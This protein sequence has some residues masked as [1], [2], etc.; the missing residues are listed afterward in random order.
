MESNDWDFCWCIS[1]FATSFVRGQSVLADMKSHFI[2]IKFMVVANAC[3]FVAV[4]IMFEY[5]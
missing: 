4:Q 1:P 3:L 2:G 5:R